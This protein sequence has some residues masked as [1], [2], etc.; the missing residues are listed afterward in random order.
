MMSLSE[1]VHDGDASWKTSGHHDA[2]AS[3][4][5]V[6]SRSASACASISTFSDHRRDHRHARQLNRDWPQ[7]S[8]RRVVGEV[9]VGEA[10]DGGMS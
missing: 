8:Q 6:T 3:S 7:G 1:I 9:E 10:N 5:R 4:T 2:F